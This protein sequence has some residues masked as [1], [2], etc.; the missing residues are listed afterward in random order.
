MKGFIDSNEVQVN[1]LEKVTFV[2][3]FMEKS[4][5]FKFSLKV[6]YKM[7]KKTENYQPVQSQEFHKK[8]G[9]H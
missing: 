7:V 9:E 6:F 3:H 8:L 5:R 1:N 2:P 4:D